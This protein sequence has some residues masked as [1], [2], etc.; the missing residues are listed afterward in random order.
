M[1]KVRQDIIQPTLFTIQA[2]INLHD[3]FSLQCLCFELYLGID[4]TCSL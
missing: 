2:H 3:V 4:V 1:S